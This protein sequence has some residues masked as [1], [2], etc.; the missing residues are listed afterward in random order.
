MACWYSAWI[1]ARVLS[2]SAIP[3]VLHL[4]QVVQFVCGGVVVLGHSYPV[5]LKFKGGKGGAYSNRRSGISNPVGQPGLSCSF[6]AAPRYNTFPYFELQLR[7]SLFSV[8]RMVCL[9]RHGFNDFFSSNTANP[10]NKVFPPHHRDAGQKRRLE[11]PVPK[12]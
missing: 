8:N 12:A 1:S 5:F 7:F 9:S 2:P 11:T 6:P 4:D 10:R 3:T